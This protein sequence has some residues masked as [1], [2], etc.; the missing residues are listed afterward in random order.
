M[1]KE[2]LLLGLDHAVQAVSPKKCKI[3]E[4]KFL[5]GIPFAYLLGQAEFYNLI[6]K[7][8][9]QVLIPRPETELLVDLIVKSGKYKSALDVGTG[10]GA[11]ILSLLKAGC[12]SEGTAVD[13]SADA[14]ELAQINAKT[15]RLDCKFILSDRLKNVSSQFDLIVSNPPYIKPKAHASLVQ[16]TVSTFEP[17]M[18]LFVEDESYEKWFDLFFKQV[19]QHLKDGG[20]FMMEGHELELDAQATQL[21]KLGFQKVEV[22]KDFGDQKR[23]LRGM[24]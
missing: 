21:K 22:L 19:F 20:V 10:S 16:K 6:L 4:S 24:K 9:S 15:H 11:I 8:N 17:G 12:V 2:N 3:L 13:L 1:Q 23:F 7:V 14:L 18:A 5:T